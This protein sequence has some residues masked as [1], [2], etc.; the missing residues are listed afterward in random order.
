MGGASNMV[1]NDSRR[2]ELV[3]LMATGGK[4]SELIDVTWMVRAY[5]ASLSTTYRRTAVFQRTGNA[6]KA[7]SYAVSVR[8]F[9]YYFVIFG[10]W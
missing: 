8:L 6:R 4:V 2:T 3:R 10:N 5:R 7:I 9:A 1:V